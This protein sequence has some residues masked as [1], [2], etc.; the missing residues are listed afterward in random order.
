VLES[1]L[2]AITERVVKAAIFADSSDAETRA[3][4]AALADLRD[5]KA[6]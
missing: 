3:A 5:G 4:P 1:Y 6:R 2:E